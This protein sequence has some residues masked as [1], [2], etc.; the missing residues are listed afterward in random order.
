MSKPESVSSLLTFQVDQFRFCVDAIE[1]EAIIESPEIN[2]VPMVPKSI[3]G[4]FSYR[5]SVAVV[6]NLRRKFGLPEPSYKISG[7]IILTRIDGELKGFLVDEVLDILENVDLKWQTLPQLGTSFISS[8]T[9][10]KDDDIFFHTNFPT[11]FAAPESEDLGSV[12][13]AAAEGQKNDESCKE[14]PG[15]AEKKDRKLENQQD[16][17]IMDS[18]ISGQNVRAEETAAEGQPDVIAESPTEPAVPEDSNLKGAVAKQTHPERGRVKYHGRAL[19]SSRNRPTAA[20]SSIGTTAP[21]ASR[22]HF[23]PAA[24][25]NIV[26][27][28]AAGRRRPPAGIYQYHRQHHRTQSDKSST[29][30]PKLV[31]GLLILFVTAAIT[32]WFWP[33]DSLSLE[34]DPPA[35]V[36]KT[37]AGSVETPGTELPAESDDSGFQK[38]VLEAAGEPS[39]ATDEDRI[40]TGSVISAER[41][42]DR[43]PVSTGE[44]TPDDEA[45]RTASEDSPAPSLLPAASVKAKEILRVDTEDFTLTVERPEPS[46]NNEAVNDLS[47]KWTAD[48]LVHIVVKGDTLWDI[49]EHYLG[50]PFRYPEL[51]ELSHIKDPHWIYPG[52]VIRIVRKKP[53]N[54]VISMK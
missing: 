46:P 35:E 44:A 53:I 42:N 24:Q 34:T 16:T 31:A 27:H 39:S 41:A 14:H 15:Q 51:A 36:S 19:N 47:A 50:N 28:P 25:R 23:R 30:W 32:A 5:G 22:N 1:A 37:D 4:V 29:L 7:Q 38:P 20:G 52:D 2:T 33:Q 8:H 9:V 49:A 11:L 48:E 3:A 43:Q 13:M 54:P 6:V 26:P 40:T 45:A 17:A 18:Q 12:L 21:P 10:L